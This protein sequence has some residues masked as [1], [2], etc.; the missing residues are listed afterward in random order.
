MGGLFS[1][2]NFWNNIITGSLYS[3]RFNVP[4]PKNTLAGH[5]EFK[6]LNSL[7][8]T[9]AR[10]FN[11]GKKEKIALA[12]VMFGFTFGFGYNLEKQT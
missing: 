7:N 1:T 5:L 6:S 2:I 4:K 9:V 3:A 12:V 8:Q 11:P 10:G